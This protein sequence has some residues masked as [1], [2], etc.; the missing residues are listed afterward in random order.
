MHINMKYGKTGLPLDL[1][2]DS[3]VTL[4]QKED[5]PVLKD[6]ETAVRSAFENPVNCKTLREE[7]KGCRS[8]CILICDITRPVPNGVILPQLIRELIEA[9]MAPG[10]ITVL[11]ATGLHRPNEGNELREL[12]GSEWVLGAVSVANHFARRDDDH[13]YIGTTSGGIEARLDRRF[14]RA[15]L[16]IVVGLVEPHFMAGYSGGRKIV[17]PGVAHEKTIRSLHCAR[18]LED[19][20]AANCILE[21][22]PLHEAQMEVMQMVGKCLAVNSVIDEDHRIS[23][24][25]FGEIVESHREAVSFVRPYAEIRLNSRYR[26][27]V[28]TSAGYPLDKTYYQTVK[29]MVSALDI[30]EPGGDLII[31]SACSEGM[32]SPDYAEAQLCLNDRGPERF[33][34]GIIEKKYAAIDEWQT[35]MQVKAMKRANIFL[36]T[37]GLT[38]DQKALTGVTIIES[39]SAAIMES[40]NAHGDRRVAVIPEGP[41]VIPQFVPGV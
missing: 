26:T 23:F 32:G 28:T 41:Y 11:V 19:N 9:G 22:N 20:N 13:E 4:I 37:E 35:E 21:G 30:V 3:E 15:D 12:V 17:V 39:P 5:M 7:A 2:G 1:P 31:V 25:N 34:R 6:P 8:C 33:L 38:K 24:V 14:V 10:S 40:V 18:V 16:R 36:Y 29:G 27:V